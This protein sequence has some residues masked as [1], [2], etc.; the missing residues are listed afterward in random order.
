VLLEFQEPFRGKILGKTLPLFTLQPNDKKWDEQVFRALGEPIARTSGGRLGS[1]GFFYSWGD[2][3]FNK[4]GIN[5]LAL[6]RDP[7]I[8]RFRIKFFGR[9]LFLSF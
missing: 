8:A 9:Q 7:S 2:I 4:T 1:E 3:S 5:E 6:Y